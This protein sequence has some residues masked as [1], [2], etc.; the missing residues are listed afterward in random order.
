MTAFGTEKTLQK[1]DIDL[2]DKGPIRIPIIVKAKADGSVA[3]VRDSLQELGRESSFDINVDTIA[4]GVGP[5]TRSEIEMA[6]ESDACVFC[7][8]IKTQDKSVL[9]LAEAEGVKVMEYDVIYSLLDD[10]KDVFMEYL[11]PVPV[12]VVHGKAAVQAIFSISGGKETIAGLKVTEGTLYKSK[13]EKDNKKSEIHFRVIR[14]GERVSPEGETIRALS[15]KK[16]KEDVE[17]VRNGEE[18]GLGL[19]GFVDFEEGDIIECYSL[20]MKKSF[21]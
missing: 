10:A 1:Y 7:F 15:L 4:Q 20:E 11:P 2:E 3:A 12:E 19:S 5:L 14:N 18:C 9:A 8:D 6:K 17:N 16:F 21:A 13:V